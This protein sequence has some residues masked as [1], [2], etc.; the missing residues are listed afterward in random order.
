MFRNAVKLRA[1]VLSA[2]RNATNTQRTQTQRKQTATRKMHMRNSQNAR[3]VP[4]RWKGMGISF[5][6]RAPGSDVFLRVCG[7]P[8]KCCL[9]PG[10]AAYCGHR[11]AN[12]NCKNADELGPKHPTVL[13]FR[14]NQ[15]ATRKTQWEHKKQ[16]EPT[17]KT[18]NAIETLS[19]LSRRL[20][21][22][23]QN[24]KRLQNA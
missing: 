15:D 2:L 7:V 13:H 6:C 19:E 17:S 4:A 12:A 3:C 16:N 22:H 9:A 11:D 5:Y 24:A 18:Q 23:E 21:T 14:K 10:S 20:A 1:E 8:A